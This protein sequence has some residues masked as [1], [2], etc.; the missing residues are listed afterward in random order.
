MKPYPPLLFGGSLL[1]AALGHVLLPLAMPGWWWLRALGGLAVVAAGALAWSAEHE[2]S[3]AQTPVMPF[4]DASSLVTSGPFR[5]SRNPIYL[6]FTLL[7][8]GVALLLA[9]WWPLITLPLAVA[10]VTGVIRVEESRLSRLF[11]DEYAEY[12][13]RTRRWL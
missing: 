10:A 7:C 6:A 11:G 9:S 2:L 13:R 8:C 1:L 3:R 5:I 12:R 4:R